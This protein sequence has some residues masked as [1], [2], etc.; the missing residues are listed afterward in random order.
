MVAAGWVI[1]NHRGFGNKK[2][3][4]QASLSGSIKSELLEQLTR[5]PAQELHDLEIPTI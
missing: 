3:M 2:L 4:T 1:E 5:S